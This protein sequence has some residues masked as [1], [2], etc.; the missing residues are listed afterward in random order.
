MIIVR[1]QGGI[2][3]QLFQ[4]AAGYALARRH[5][6]PLALDLSIF[7]RE[8]VRYYALDRFD[9]PQNIVSPPILRTGSP[10][11]RRTMAAFGLRFFLT[12][13]EPHFHYD[14]K[15]F[16]LIP[17]VQIRGYFQ[18]ERYFSSV[19]QELRPQLRLMA[20]LS[21]AAQDAARQIA[22]AALPISVHIR[23]GDYL[24]SR[25]PQVLDLAYYRRAHEIMS[26]VIGTHATYFVF[27]DDY[28]FAAANFEFLPERVIVRG[29]PNRSWE[30]LMLM[31]RCRHHIIANS[32][33]SWWGAWLNA[34][35][36]KRIIAPRHW[37]NPTD[38]P[39]R[40]TGDVYPVG[41]ILI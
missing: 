25:N 37:F 27:S 38:V 5:G 13:R 4:Y 6:C 24:T 30:D 29:D 12:Y 11:A 14:E 28:D 41:A 32:S 1:L 36:D 33:F 15:L 20:P 18:S 39:R 21:D 3:N 7:T 9:I 23:R 8:K 34:D 16:D 2:G 31:S 17:P 35:P 19:A 22:A 40:N 26:A 10:A